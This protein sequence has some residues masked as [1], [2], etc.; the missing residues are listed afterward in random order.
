MHYFLPVLLLA[1]AAPC[2]A[3]LRAGAA[4]REVTPDLERHAPVYIPGFANNRIATGVHDPLS[5]RCLA[6]QAGQTVVICGVDSIGLFLDDVKRIREIAAPRLPKGAQVIVAATHDHE[7]V[8]TMGLWG[9]KQ[10]V[11]GINEEYSKFLIQQ[12]ADAA[13]EAASKLQPARARFVSARFPGIEAYFDDSRPPVVNDPDIVAA[14]FTTNSG[15]PIATLVNWANHP[16]ALGSKNTLITAD[17][18]SYLY[19]TLEE[20]NTGVT[21]FINGAVGG[22]QSP[23]GAKIPNPVTGKIQPDSTFDFAEIVGNRVA[24]TIL[25]T[26]KG[27]LPSTIT[28]V[29]YVEKLVR[30]PLTNQGYLAG[31]KAGVFKG[32]KKFNDDGTTEAPVGLLT[33]SDNV[34]PVLQAILIP[35]ELYPELS[36]GGAVRGPGSDF[37]NAPFEPP[38]KNLLKAQYKMLFGLANDEIGYIIPKAQWDEKPPYTFGA[39][40]RWYGEVNSVGPDAAPIITA[41]IA[42]LIMKSR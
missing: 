34:Q 3:Q 21:V 36:V 12:T 40:K 9:P 26:L 20:A 41:A 2:F 31:A 15:K 11:S 6:L 13:V 8:D 33:L 22:M 29:V 1:L 37:P 18:P 10:G 42:D 27:V 24:Y 17:W 23:L 4:T 16:E 35:G 39:T 30:I 32:R 38:L 14:A 19:K 5:A 25:D 7:S 28:R